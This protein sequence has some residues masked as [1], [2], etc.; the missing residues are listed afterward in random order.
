MSI[1]IAI[2]GL[3]YVGLPLA[4]A[5]SEKYPVI[6]FDINT[7]RI[8][9]LLSGFDRTLELSSEQVKDSISNGMVYTTNLEDIK[10][11]N[12]YIVTVPTPIDASNEPDLTPIIK[13]TQS[14]AK[15]LKEG[16]IVIYESTVYPGVTEEVC[17]PLLEEGSGLKFNEGFFCGYSPERINPGDKEHTVTK[18]L[19]ITSGS[20]PEIAKKVDDLYRSI[21]T[22]GTHLA[23][24]IK[25]AEA[26]K[27]IEN[28]QRDVNIAL[29][30]EL[31]QIFDLMG[32]NTHDVI[33][34]AATKWNFIK[35]FPGLVGGHCIGVDPYYLTHKAQSLGYMP[36]LILGARQI[37]N[38]MSKLI[39]DKTIKQMIK[40]DKKL[41]GA[42]V[43]VMGVTFKENCPDMRNSKVLDIIK[44]LEDYE[45]KVDVY[46]YWVDR[47][48]RETK[49]LNF[50]DELPLDSGKYDA[51][52]VAVG[53]DKFKE[54]TTEQY[55]SMSKGAPIVM[56]VKGIV[57]NPTWRL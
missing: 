30:N 5:F 41:K 54:I 1:K 34:A 16:D 6:G 39:V 57:E 7:D 36:N 26:A 27:V 20:T 35:L 33:E 24:T 12:I 9:E 18:I 28:T 11:S 48:D 56:D 23:P 46:D 45:C 32:I 4:H 17:V 37:N 13:S 38:G 15:V 3:G 22:A 40:E 19:K 52:I 31:A 51:I 44:E 43:L 50:V 53:H 14:V 21:I 42:N 25:V 49:R 55:K 29:I 2:I 47:S 10:D 8:D